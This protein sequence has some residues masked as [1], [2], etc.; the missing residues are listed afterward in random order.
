MLHRD[1]QGCKSDIV[2]EDFPWAEIRE[3][4]GKEL[5]NLRDRDLTI[6]KSRLQSPD[7]R[8]GLKRAAHR[9]GW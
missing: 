5:L 2:S 3:E 9:G 6:A 7:V 8:A 1:R 4:F